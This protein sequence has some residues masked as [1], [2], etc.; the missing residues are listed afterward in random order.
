MFITYKT[1][2]M[3]CK[4]LLQYLRLGWLKLYTIVSLAARLETVVKGGD[5]RCQRYNI[6][7]LI[8]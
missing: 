1:T 2:G 4:S 7:A 5:G 3:N 8:L 6:T